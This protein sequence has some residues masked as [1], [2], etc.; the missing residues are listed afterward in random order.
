MEINQ[1]NLL[2]QVQFERID[3]RIIKK[4]LMKDVQGKGIWNFKIK[5][6][7]V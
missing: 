5:K 3:K 4:K 6:E 1:R 2:E 7:Y